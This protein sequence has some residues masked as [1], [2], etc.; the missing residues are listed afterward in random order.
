MKASK[1]G[2]QSTVLPSYDTDKPCQ[3]PAWFLEENLQPHSLTRPAQSLTTIY[4]HL[5]L[6]LEMKV[7]LT[8]H[9]RDASLCNR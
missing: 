2:K 3:Q 8:S 6:Y 9:Q 7:V 4:K 1:E 5:S